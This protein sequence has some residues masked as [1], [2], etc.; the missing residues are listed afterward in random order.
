VT[1][2]NIS[3]D[4]IALAPV[5][6]ALERRIIELEGRVN[7]IGLAV[8]RA[9]IPDP[10]HNTGLYQAREEL[11]HLRSTLDQIKEKMNG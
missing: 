3:L 9:D 1:R 4:P 11:T 5:R 7:R 8:Y 6:R 2:V 10:R